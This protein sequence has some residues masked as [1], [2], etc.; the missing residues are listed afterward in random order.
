MA[1]IC[2][3]LNAEEEQSKEQVSLKRGRK[4]GIKSVETK[5]SR[6]AFCWPRFSLR[7]RAQIR[8]LNFQHRDW[9]YG[10]CSTGICFISLLVDMGLQLAKIMGSLETEVSLVCSQSALSRAMALT[11]A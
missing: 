4:W 9:T 8:L 11:D 5:K 2:T 6:E 10:I 7:N 1:N 3:Y